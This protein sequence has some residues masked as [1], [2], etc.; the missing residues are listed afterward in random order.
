M[1]NLLS[2][3]V[4]C[5]TAIRPM[6][7]TA[8]ILLLAS[9][10]TLAQESPDTSGALEEITVTAQFVRQNLQDT[11]VAI[12]AVSAATLESRGHQSIE[13]IANQTPNVTLTTG[14]AYGGP[15]LVGF[16]RGVGQTDFDPALEPGVGL[17]VDDVYYST[18]TGSVLDLLD[19]DRVE[20]LRGP[21]GTLAGKNSIGGSI[22]LYSKKPTAENDGYIEAG[23]GSYNAVTVR[24]A[25]NF[26]LIPDRLFARVS[27]VS[28]ARDGYIRRFDYGCTHPG[29]ALGAAFPSEVQG[30]PCELG[31]EGGIRYTAARL[32]LRWL[33]TE[34]LEFNIAADVLNDVSEAPANVL[35]GVGPTVAPIIVNG[36]IWPN[37]SGV[38]A[39]ISGCEF[40]TY[41]SGSCDSKRPNNPYANYATYTDP[42]T[43]LA[44]TPNQTVKSRDLSLNA[45]WKLSDTLELQSI[46]AYR[47]FVSGFGDDQTASPIPAADLY[48][49]LT[50]HQSSEELRLNG[51]AAT[52][53]DYT[54]GAF[55]FDQYTAHDGR[56]DLGY[57]GFDFVHGPDP[58]NATTWAIFTHGII[59]ATDQLDLSLG[60]RYSDDKKDYSYVRHNPDGTAIQP[61]V[62]PPG[63]PGNPPNCLISS[64]NGV[65]SEFQGTRTDYRAALSYRWTTGLMTYAQF[66]TGYKGGGVNPRPFYNVQAITFRPETINAFEIGM[67]SQMLDNHLRVNVAAFYNKY[68]DI[69]L[70]LN[71][72]TALFGPL[73]IPCLLPAN[74]GD[75]NVKGAEM[76]LDW[77]PVTGLQ[78]D[79]SY[80]HLD[81]K[82]TRINA[83]TGLDLSKITPYTPKN[84]WSAGVQYEVQLGSAGSVIPRVDASYQAKVYGDIDNTALGTIDSHTLVN[85]RLTWL[86]PEK[87][88]QASIECQN[89]TDKLYYLSKSDGTFNGSGYAFGAPGLPR[90]VMFNVKRSF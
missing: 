78:I 66:S 86:S 11:P 58:V 43:G 75:A 6:G 33:A 40:I 37:L 87:S 57:A 27:G 69:Q 65:S 79:S 7:Q 53:L 38:P 29:S 74:A 67:K 39:N 73:G 24:G 2:V 30:P 22:K 70:V 41:G 52:L 25:S 62:G 63:T 68:K 49:T 8:L 61:C 3:W 88:W 80:S 32:A 1:N 10:A 17:Y 23:Y 55:Y 4:R 34:N 21:Q 14:G 54:V 18:L 84:K 60:V 81:F 45:D 72:C 5:C 71:D 44:I 51:K 13:S 90:T 15:S 26:T 59:H 64:L 12:T 28:R 36:V 48:Q 46:S 47:R 56:I 9:G 19:L 16:I 83:A 85:G 35:L 77:T 89:M 50:H 42:R 20:I 31:T 82:M 76:E